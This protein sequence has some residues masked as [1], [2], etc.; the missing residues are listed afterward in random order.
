MGSGLRNAELV[1]NFVA[2]SRPANRSSRLTSYW[3]TVG[4]GR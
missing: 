4:L 2:D 3:S 1:A